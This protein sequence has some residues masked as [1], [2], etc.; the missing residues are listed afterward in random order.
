MQVMCWAPSRQC[1][2]ETVLACLCKFDT[3]YLYVFFNLLKLRTFVNVCVR[4]R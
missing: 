4:K 1:V 2:N 3:D